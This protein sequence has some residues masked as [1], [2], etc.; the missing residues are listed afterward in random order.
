MRTLI[1]LFEVLPLRVAGHRLVRLA[2]LAALDDDDVVV[3]TQPRIIHLANHISKLYISHRSQ[4][5]Q[6]Q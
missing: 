3:L 6:L 4:P 1:E 5:T 2:V